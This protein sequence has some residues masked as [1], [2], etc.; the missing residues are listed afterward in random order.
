MTRISIELVCKAE[1]LTIGTI[2]AESGTT[3]DARYIR[4]NFSPNAPEYDL[5]NT[6]VEDGSGMQCPRCRN[7]LLFR[8][9]ATGK[10]V[11]AVPGSVQAAA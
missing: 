1:N 4:S 7:P 6:S 10:G 3:L 8:Q 2:E 9:S 5:G 11:Y